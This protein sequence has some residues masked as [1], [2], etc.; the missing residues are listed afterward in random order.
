MELTRE[1]VTSFGRT[2]WLGVVLVVALFLSVG[3]WMA[4]AGV[5]GAVIGSGAVIVKGKP[6]SIQ[7][8]DGGIINEIAVENGQGVEYDQLL[9][10]IRV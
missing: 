8:L 2:G 3:S 10:G 5:A 9:F 6:K 1:P 4:Y 7:H